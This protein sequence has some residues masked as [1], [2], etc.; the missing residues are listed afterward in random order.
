[1]NTNIITRS[2][3]ILSALC[4]VALGLTIGTAAAGDYGTTTFSENESIAMLDAI[5]RDN[6]RSYSHTP[7]AYTNFSE[8]ESIALLDAVNRDNPVAGVVIAGNVASYGSADFAENESIALVDAINRGSQTRSYVTN[9][10]PS[11][12]LTPAPAAAY[13]T[14]SEA[15]DS[16]AQTQGSEYNG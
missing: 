14:E 4:A 2:K 9:Y 5:N 11:Y 6:P 12:V 1:M 3:K 13:V 7:A 8:N 16:M 15:A 10:A